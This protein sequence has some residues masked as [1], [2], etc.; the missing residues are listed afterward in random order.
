MHERLKTQFTEST[1]V[2]TRSWPK[3]DASRRVRPTS[4][5]S[6]CIVFT[7]A[8]SDCLSNIYRNRTITA[9]SRLMTVKPSVN[10]NSQNSELS[11]AYL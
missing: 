2:E 7:S 8:K 10:A 5:A 9:E 11:I 3:S 4:G 1:L 6:Q